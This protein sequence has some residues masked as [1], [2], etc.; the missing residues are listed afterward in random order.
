LAT[1]GSGARRKDF[2]A[3]LSLKDTW[4]D[5]WSLG[6]VTLVPIRDEVWVY[7]V[8]FTE[9]PPPRVTPPGYSGCGMSWSEPPT[10]HIVVLPN[11]HAVTPTPA[12][13]RQRALTIVSRKPRSTLLPN[14]LMLRR[15]TF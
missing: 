2:M 15:G 11:G 1:G 5:R 13:P 9:G 14:D 6:S 12:K 4:P 10:V 3:R 7:V 8:D